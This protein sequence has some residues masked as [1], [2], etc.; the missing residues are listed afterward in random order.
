MRRRNFEESN[1][2]NSDDWNLTKYDEKYILPT[3]GSANVSQ[4]P[5]PVPQSAASVATDMKTETVTDVYS[6]GRG[7]G[8]E[9]VETERPMVF[10]LRAYKDVYVYEYKDRLEYYKNTPDGMV[11]CNTEYKKR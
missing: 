6:V 3:D 2:I 1:P 11:K 5:V 10:A 9:S 7:Y 8:R 4:D